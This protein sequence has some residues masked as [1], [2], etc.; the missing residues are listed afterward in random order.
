M[1]RPL[2][3]VCYDVRCPKRWRRI[4]ALLKRRGAH[5]QLSVFLLRLDQ[6]AIQKL[7]MDLSLLINP[8]EDSVLIVKIEGKTEGLTELGLPGPMPGA[9]IIVV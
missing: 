5:R 4:F 2:H 3:L 8:A 9:R 6:P 7:R 1:S